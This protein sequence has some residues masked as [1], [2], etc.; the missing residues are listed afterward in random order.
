M[1]ELNHADSANVAERVL[2][3]ALAH[4]LRHDILN[5]CDNRPA[6]PTEL[7]EETGEDFKRVCHHVTYLE[8][9]GLLELVETDNRKGGTQHFYRA[10]RRPLVDMA[11]ADALSRVIRETQSASALRFFLADLISASEAGTLD[12]HEQR[13]LLREKHILDDQGMRESAEAAEAFQDLL[14]DIAAHSADRLAHSRQQGRTVASHTSI[15][16]LPDH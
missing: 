7:A 9:H 3:R 12:D 10:I 8:R 15:F 5:I 14:K 13:S 4:P 1:P 2:H 11:Q 16:T 6:S